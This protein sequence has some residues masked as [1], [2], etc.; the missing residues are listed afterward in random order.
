M[1]SNVQEE[2]V[3]VHLGSGEQSSIAEAG[4]ECCKVVGDL[5]GSIEWWWGVLFSPGP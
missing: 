2:Y 1:R 3:K 5:A 4:S